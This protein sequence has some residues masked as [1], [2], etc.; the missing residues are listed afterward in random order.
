MHNSP[1]TPSQPFC[2][3]LKEIIQN[4]KEVEIHTPTLEP[5]SGSVMK[6]TAEMSA[7]L[8]ADPILVVFGGRLRSEPFDVNYSVEKQRY[9][10][11]GS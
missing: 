3:V 1:F 9:L 4:R 6:R 8:A 2:S 11:F 5:M 10:G 7:F